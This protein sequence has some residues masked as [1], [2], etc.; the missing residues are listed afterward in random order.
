MSY[1]QY[2]EEV[3]ILKA[4]ENARMLG[5]HTP[6]SRCST[7]TVCQWCDLPKDEWRPGTLCKERIM[8]R[9][10]DIGAFNPTV[11]SNTRALY[12]LGWEGVMIEPSPG[13]MGNLLDAYGNDERITLVSAAVGIEPGFVRLHITDDGVST[14]DE[15][16]YAKW[17][18]SATFRGMMTAPVL[19]LEQI[20]NQFGH[21]HFWNIDAEGFSP[22]IFRRMIDL[23]LRPHCVCVEHDGRVAELLEHACPVGYK[24]VYANATNLVV[25]R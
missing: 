5:E 12:E 10:L 25:T 11:F 17:Q 2:G 23:E 24:A 22:D 1:S 19:T 3:A 16:A 8:G 18:N 15:A 6:I 7:R 9:F 21:F 13:P 20:C 4:F 14:G